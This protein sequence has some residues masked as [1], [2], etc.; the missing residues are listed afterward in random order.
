[1]PKQMLAVQGNV[2]SIL[3]NALD[4]IAIGLE[5]F[6]STDDRRVISSTRNIFAGI[7][8]LF[9]HQLCELS[10]EGSDEAL[11]KQRVLPEIDATGAINWIGKGKKTVDVQNIK[12]RFESLNISVDWKKLERINKYRNDIEHYYSTLNN[13]SV[14]QLISDSFLI[15]RDFIADE[16]QEDPKSLLGE[17]YWKILVDVNEV[18][19]KEKLECDNSLE[20]LDYFSSEILSALQAH[21]C[22][23]CGSGLIE[24][25]SDSGPA[26]ES[27]FKCRACEDETDYESL[28][29]GVINNFYADDVY[30]SHKDGDESPVVDC[31]LCCDGVYLFH[32]GI[33]TSCGESAAHECERC[34]CNIPAE[35]ISEDN[36]CGYCSHMLEKIMAE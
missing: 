15:I 17:E 5:D 20:N 14:Q 30:L 10:P 24:S 21:R 9:K 26:V 4:S 16:L 6:E 23:K 3:Q 22:N 28:I 2:M 12:E 11:I 27:S 34:G 31:P 35:E 36:V 19:A 32:E 7:L 25:T 8:L 29:N 18:Y 13:N 33:C 1:M